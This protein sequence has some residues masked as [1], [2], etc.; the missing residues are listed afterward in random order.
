MAE[1]QQEYADHAAQWQQAI[2]KNA[3][4]LKKSRAQLKQLQQKQK[5][6][7]KQAEKKATKAL[8]KSERI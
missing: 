4:L 3:E 7:Q 5:Q 8:T 6:S 1:I 2:K